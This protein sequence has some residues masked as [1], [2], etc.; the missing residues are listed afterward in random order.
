MFVVHNAVLTRV[1]A[2]LPKNVKYATKT[3]NNFVVIYLDTV[4]H[5]MQELGVG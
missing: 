2:R 5:F 4:D 1:L 3:V